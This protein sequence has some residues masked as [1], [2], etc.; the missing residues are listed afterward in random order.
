MTIDNLLKYN[1]S[2]SDGTSTDY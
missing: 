2:S 1:Q